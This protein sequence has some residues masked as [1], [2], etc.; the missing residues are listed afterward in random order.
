MT[1]PWT[2]LAARRTGM[3]VMRL[4]TEPT[5]DAARARDTIAA[6]LDA[7]VVL[8]DTSDAYALEASE[9]GHSERALREILAAREGP[10]PLVVTKGGLRRPKGRWVP[11]GRAKWLAEACA[12][13]C[14]ALGVEAVDLYLLHAVDPKT[15][16]QTSA[17]ALA[18]LRDE[19]RARA[20][21]LCNV[22]VGELEAVAKHGPWAAVEVELGL[23]NPRAI[24]SGVVE[25]AARHGLWLLAH[26]P[27]GGV[28]AAGRWPR[29]R[30]LAPVAESLGVSAHAVGLAYLRSLGP[31]IVP[32]PGPTTPAHAAEAGSDLVLDASDLRHLDAAFEVHAS[33]RTPRAKRRPKAPDAAH[34]V[35]LTMGIP[36]S[37][38]STYAR[39]LQAQGYLRLNRDELGGT[40]RGIRKRFEAALEDGVAKVV[41]DNTYVERALRDEILEVAWRHGRDVRCVWAEV[42]PEVA[43]VR[44]ILRMLDHCGRLVD[45]SEL[46]Q[47]QK[48]APNVVGPSVV[49]RFVERLE[50]PAEDEGFSAI[51]VLRSELRWPEAWI[52]SGVIV[53]LDSGL[54][55]SAR[56]D[57]APLTPEDVVIDEAAAEAVRALERPVA[58][59]A[60]APEVEAGQQTEAAL[61][62]VLERTQALLPFDVDFAVCRHGPGPQSCWCR[63]PMP[64]LGVELLRRNRWDPR[65]TRMLG[66]TPAEKSF[67]R[68]LGLDF[69]V[70]E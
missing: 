67:A 6:G 40:L 35:V 62:A 7:G 8:L 4:S 22:T 32:L 16:L 52:G 36:G 5:R 56:G 42:P 24:R 13:S 64:G 27:F 37:G 70:V 53:A 68:R 9:R 26:R 38:K 21:G 48:E 1:D 44:A 61:Q 10:R 18:R 12:D 50:P 3:G 63:L 15:K 41:L 19:G 2:T 58:A 17:R 55:R 51:E 20:V 34:D 49:Q 45:R 29:H 31:H 69:I 57:R 47:V 39:T 43:Q 28:K 54:R 30:A 60:W 66:R 46:A 25:Y 23:G 65:R 14:A 33:L 11:D 59:I